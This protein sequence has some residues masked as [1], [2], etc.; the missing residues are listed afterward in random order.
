MTRPI[1]YTSLACTTYY[2][3]SLGRWEGGGGVQIA[4]VIPFHLNYLDPRHIIN[5][6][7][8]EMGMNADSKTIFVVNGIGVKL[9]ADHAKWVQCYYDGAMADG[10]R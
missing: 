3:F 2:L 4:C 1:C 6:S 7:G 10:K 9:V 8:T 5:I